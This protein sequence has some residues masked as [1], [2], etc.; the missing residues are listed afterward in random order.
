MQNWDKTIT[1]IPT[2]ALI[3]ESF[4]NWRGMQESGGR[5][6]K[7]TINLDLSSIKFCDQQMLDQFAKIQYIADYI[8]QKQEEIDSY[9]AA[10]QVD[11]V[12]LVNG[13]L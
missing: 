13:R 7:R 10:N 12:S 9:N 3:S 8:K 5:R 1:T 11:Q 6:I 4:K 2:Y